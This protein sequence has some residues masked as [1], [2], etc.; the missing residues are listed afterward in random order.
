[1][2]RGRLPPPPAC[3]C[4]SRLRLHPTTRIAPPTTVIPHPAPRAHSSHSATAVRGTRVKLVGTV[5]GLWVSTHAPLPPLQRGARSR[6][7]PCL[8]SASPQRLFTA[9]STLPSSTTLLSAY[10]PNSP[11]PSPSAS[12]LLSS[13]ITINASK[14]RGKQEPYEQNRGGQGVADSGASVCE[15]AVLVGQGGTPG[16]TPSSRAHRALLRACEGAAWRGPATGGQHVCVCA[17]VV[18]CVW[19]VQGPSP[20]VSVG[21]DDGLPQ[22]TATVQQLALPCLALFLP[23]RRLLT[24]PSARPPLSPPPDLPTTPPKLLHHPPAKVSRT[25]Q[26][27]PEG[28]GEWGPWEMPYCNLPE[29]RHVAALACARAF[30]HAQ[31]AW[32]PAPVH[33]TRHHPLHT[34]ALLAL[35]TPLCCALQCSRA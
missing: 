3:P 19:K 17:S 35:H 15:P 14:Q 1:M 12:V 26:T 11:C 29:A 8:Q 13:T 6:G 21:V 18:V 30:P 33:S 23:P 16:H 5:G 32:P 10:L 7:G 27:S 22:R 2:R 4:S 20:S 31:H 9:Q 28:C 24:P 25:Q 34:L